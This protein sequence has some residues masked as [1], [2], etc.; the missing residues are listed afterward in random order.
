MAL[1]SRGA[2]R[3]TVEGVAYRWVVAPNEGYL[4]LVV[5]RADDPGQRLE[6]SFNYHDVAEPAE[7]GSSRTVGQLRSIGPGATR[8]VILAAL[9]RGWQPSRKGLPP[10]RLDGEV[11]APIDPPHPDA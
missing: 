5:E 3:I 4:I 11:A 6:A 8:S 7:A 9:G 1:A 10:F 2:R